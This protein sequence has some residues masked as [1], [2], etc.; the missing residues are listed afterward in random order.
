MKT[1][2]ILKLTGSNLPIL[3]ATHKLFHHIFSLIVPRRG[4]ERSAGWAPG[5]QASL[6]HHSNSLKSV[7]ML[8]EQA[9]AEL[10]LLLYWLHVLY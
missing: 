10:G 5:G 9:N 6:T 2:S 3:I 4:S 8:K 7:W 1:I